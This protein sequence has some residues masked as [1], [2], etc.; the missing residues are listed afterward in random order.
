MASEFKQKTQSD[1]AK[2]LYE[3]KEALKSFRFNLAGSKTKNVKEGRTLRKE[4]AHILT[5]MGEKVRAGED[6]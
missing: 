1:L 4:I 2:L 3:K 5:V 6:K